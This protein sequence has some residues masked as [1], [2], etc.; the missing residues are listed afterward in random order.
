M[1]IAALLYIMR[2]ERAGTRTHGHTDVD[3]GCGQFMG[4]IIDYFRVKDDARIF[5]V[6]ATFGVCGVVVEYLACALVRLPLSNGA[7]LS[8]YETLNRNATR[9]AIRVRVC[10]HD[11]SS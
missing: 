6:V 3:V 7:R 8:G 2:L 10:S 5:G 11:T 4:H 9:T 1:Y